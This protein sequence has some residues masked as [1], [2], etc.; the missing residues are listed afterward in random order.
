M[1]QKRMPDKKLITKQWCI[2]LTLS[3]LVLLL[4]LLFQF[5]LPLSEG[6]TAAEV[7]AVVWPLAVVIVLVLL[8]V[9]GLTTLTYACTPR[10]S[11]WL[12]RVADKISQFL[13]SS[14]DVLFQV[15]PENPPFS[16]AESLV[17]PS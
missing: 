14:G 10:I 1:E 9:S 4:A 8:L 2:L 5:L 3:A 6:I 7:S 12:Y 13:Q 16:L 15:D 17:I 11:M